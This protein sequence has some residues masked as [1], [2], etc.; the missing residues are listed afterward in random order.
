MSGRI[1]RLAEFGELSGNVADGLGADL[2]ELGFGEIARH[3]LK[4]IEYDVEQNIL[5]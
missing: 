5:K 3:V 1:Q 2:D 4:A